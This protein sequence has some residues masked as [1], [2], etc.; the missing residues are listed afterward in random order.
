MNTVKVEI[1]VATQQVA[2]ADAP[3]LLRVALSGQ[4]SVD[5][6]I[7]GPYSA[8]FTVADGSYTGSIQA[9]RADGSPVG[10]A[11]PFSVNAPEGTISTSAPVG[12]SVSV[13]PA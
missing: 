7:T 9:I 5:L 2:A 12:V 13:Q 1:T 8:E 6:P 10:V 3:A 11:V 4:P